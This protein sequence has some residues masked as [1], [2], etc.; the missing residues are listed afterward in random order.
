[1]SKQG[2]EPKF[3]T[4]EELANMLHVKKRTV[5]EWVSRGIIPYRKAGN[6]TLF[7]LDEILEWT[8][9]SK[10]NKGIPTVDTKLSYKRHDGCNSE[11][12]THHGS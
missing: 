9:S 12:K 2:I 11:R 10:G 5:Y 1:M 6:R 8:V 3:L 4:V 7:L